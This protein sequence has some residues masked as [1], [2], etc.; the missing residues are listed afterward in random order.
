MMVRAM[1][2]LISTAVTSLLP[3]VSDRA[4]SQPPPGPITSV[5]APGRSM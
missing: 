3:P 5:F 2:G 4:T 1:I